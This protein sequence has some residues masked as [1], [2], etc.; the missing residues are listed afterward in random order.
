M[1]RKICH[2]SVKL[3]I[4]QGITCSLYKIN[5]TKSYFNLSMLTWVP[6][7]GTWKANKNVH[8]ENNM[9]V[10]SIHAHTTCVESIREH[11]AC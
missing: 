1:K 10:E 6:F 7:E 8:L 9:L 5:G 3:Y 4:A 2:F 11:A